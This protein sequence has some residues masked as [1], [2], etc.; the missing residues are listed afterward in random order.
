MWY[1]WDDGKNQANIEKHGIAFERV[2]DFCWDTAFAFLDDRKDDG[3]ARWIALGAINTRL[4]MLIFT[5]SLEAL[6]VISPRKAND[7]EGVLY[8]ARKAKT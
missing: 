2:S 4:H 8:E 1:E 7:R 6:R 3:E 5:R